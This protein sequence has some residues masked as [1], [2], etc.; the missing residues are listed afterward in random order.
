[1]G[2]TV[3]ELTVQTQRQIPDS[4]SSREKSVNDVMHTGLGGLCCF[5]GWVSLPGPWPSLSVVIVTRC[6]KAQLCQLFYVSVMPGSSEQLYSW[7]KEK[8]QYFSLSSPS[9]KPS[10]SAFDMFDFLHCANGVR[11]MGACK[12]HILFTDWSDWFQ[13]KTPRKC[14]NYS[15]VLSGNTKPSY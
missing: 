2:C 9:W 4:H 13:Y 10:I 1:M 15:D 3:W 6:L 5:H 7:Y 8:T 12:Y 14:F 11:V